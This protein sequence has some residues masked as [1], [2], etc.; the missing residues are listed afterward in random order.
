MNL[1]VPLAML[2][3][4]DDIDVFELAAI[5]PAE[6]GRPGRMDRE[7]G[8]LPVHLGKRELERSLFDTRRHRRRLIS[9]LPGGKPVPVRKNPHHYEHNCDS[10]RGGPPSDLWY[11]ARIHSDAR[12]LL[13][14]V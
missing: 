10:R 1:V 5:F 2:A 12:P 13:L 14:L 9:H 4:H 8:L 3:V 11:R 7:D 6:F